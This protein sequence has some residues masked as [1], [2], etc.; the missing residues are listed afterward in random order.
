MKTPFE[1]LNVPEDAD[2]R[3][4]KDAYL[5]A[6][7]QFPPEHH[8]EQFKRIRQAYERIATEEDRLRFLLF[9]TSIP[10]PVD[11]VQLVL[12]SKKRD[13]AD[14]RKNFRQLLGDSLKFT[15]KGFE[16]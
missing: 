7:R 15:A 1:I 10:D 14:L 2:D 4:I 8:P 5:Q 16:I 6:V 12:D 9:D 13:R 3:Q 11:M